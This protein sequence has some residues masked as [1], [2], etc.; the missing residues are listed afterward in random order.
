MIT[1]PTTELIGGLTDVLPIIT[2][3]KSDLAGVVVEW[4]GEALHFTAYDVYSGATVLWI[5]GEGAEGDDESQEYDQDETDFGGDDAPWRTWI[6][7]DSAKEI[8]KLFKLPA[9]LWRTPVT[10]KCTPVGDL[11]IER[12]DS[13]RGNRELRVPGDPD[14]ARSQIPHV[15]ETFAKSHEMAIPP[16]EAS[17]AFFHQRLGA[18]GAARAHGTMTLWFGTEG[19][20]VGVRIGTRYRGFIYPSG[21]AN[22]RPFNLLRDGA[23]GVTHV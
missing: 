13:P 8:L 4:D 3:P 15:G 2:D 19:E 1:I 22:V 20:P 23:G 7:L 12:I 9:K 21:A 10:L 5:P 11:L 17:I 6:W 14:K 18:F 16:R